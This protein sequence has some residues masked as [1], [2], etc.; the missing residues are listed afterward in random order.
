VACGL[1]GQTLWLAG[2]GLHVVALDVSPVA[3]AT[4][5]E[6]AAA[7]GLSGRVDA[8]VTDLDAGLPPE[9]ATVDVIVCQRFRQPALYP[10]FA[11]RL[12]PGGIGLVTVLSEVGTDSPG[13]F[14][15]PPGELPA[16]FDRP[17]IDVLHHDE[18]AG[19]AS[20]VFRRR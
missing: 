4:V 14:H 12:R 20:I 17:D 10:Q 16:A 13:V 11:D 3:I 6:S 9:P 15:A 2:R 1:G 8:R 5:V 19:Q 18:R 7:A